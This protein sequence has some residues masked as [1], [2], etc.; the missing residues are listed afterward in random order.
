MGKHIETQEDTFLGY[1]MP[2]MY[3]LMCAEGQ[4]IDVN[5][6]LD[7][8]LR[9]P[10]ALMFASWACTGND[11]V[12]RAATTLSATS[13]RSLSLRT[14]ASDPTKGVL[15]LFKDFVSDII[16]NAMSD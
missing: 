2:S 6:D 10:I 9:V 8:H 15:S 3:R 5:L 12:L 4:Y 16:C 11:F 1:P 14:G 13:E 7:P